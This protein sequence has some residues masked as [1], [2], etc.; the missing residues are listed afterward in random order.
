MRILSYPAYFFGVYDNDTLIAVNSGY[1]TTDTEFR[2][3]GLWV[4]T[5]YRG[6]GIAQQL[7]L[8]TIQQAQLS[9]AS[10]IWSIPRLTAVPAYE[11]AGFITVGEPISEQVEFGPNIYC[12]KELN[13]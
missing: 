12:V 6:M 5:A 11:R 13:I 10:M 7:L 8:T 2:S 4:D 3:R 9:G 1:L